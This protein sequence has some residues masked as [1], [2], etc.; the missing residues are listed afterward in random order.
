VTCD[1]F[2][3]D[4]QKIRQWLKRS[5]LVASEGVGHL[6][7]CAVVTHKYNARAVDKKMAEMNG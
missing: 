6:E 2:V 3:I 7:Y 5:S 1:F 4:D